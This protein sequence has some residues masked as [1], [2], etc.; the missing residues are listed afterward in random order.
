[1]FFFYEIKIFKYIGEESRNNYYI[2]VCFDVLGNFYKW[3][4]KKCKEIVC[5]NWCL[6]WIWWVDI[7]NKILFSLF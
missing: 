4:F 3:Y 2:S 7:N 6:N 5:K 1:M